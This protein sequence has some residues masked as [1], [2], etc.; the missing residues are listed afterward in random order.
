MTDSLHQG[1]A[2]GKFLNLQRL[3]KHK[4]TLE[5]VMVSWMNQK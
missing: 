1:K 3:N 5:H 2:S 4:T